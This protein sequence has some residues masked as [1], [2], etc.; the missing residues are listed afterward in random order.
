MVL[1][2]LSFQ[3][4]FPRAVLTLFSLVSLS[5]LRAQTESVA[6]TMPEDYLPQ[7]KP[8]LARA[9]QLSPDRVVKLLEIEHQE[10]RV[11][12]ARAPQLPQVGGSF[13]YGITESAITRAA[14]EDS[15]SS[16]SGF[17][18]DASAN[19]AIYHWGALKNAADIERLRLLITRKDT[20][21]ASRDLAVLLRKMYLSLV[22]Q[23]A[24][25]LAGRRALRLLDDELAVLAIR[26]EQGFTSPASVEGRKLDRREQQLA[27]DRVEADFAADRRRLSRLAGLPQLLGEEDVPATLAKP[28]Y[29][30]PTTAQMTAKLLRENA[31]STLE[32]EIYDLRVRAALKQE[33]IEA[34]RLFP[35]FGANVSYSLQNNTSVEA[36]RTNQEAVRVQSASVGGNW[37]I[38]DGFATKGAKR[39]ALVARRL[40]EFQRTTG[41][42]TLMQNAQILQR[43]LKLDREQMELT[44]IRQ[45]MATDIRRRAA[46]EAELGKLA[47]AEI[48]RAE[49]GVLNAEVATIVH[50][51]AFLVHWSEFVAVAGNDPVL[52]QLP[53]S[54]AR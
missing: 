46:E 53:A 52:T 17:F 18:Y 24:Q 50:R 12:I 30:E 33:K 13:R 44:E 31:Q 2:G 22:I 8:I 15:K 4:V 45:A 14:S 51:V 23:K 9:M 19:Q 25:L 47:R 16:G 54:N 5:F 37:P 49:V 28:S 6:G 39:E 27:V 29:S 36:G 1:T 7:L 42:E 20:V 10:A 34:V 21:R 41:T 48:E 38:F 32:Y 11:I 43:A 3:R 26:L 40:A 35:K